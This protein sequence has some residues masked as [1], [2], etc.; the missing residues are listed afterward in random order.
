MRLVSFEAGAA[1]RF[2]AMIGDQIAD[3]SREFGVPTLREALRAGFDKAAW[4]AASSTA[5]KYDAKD[6]TF[7]PPITDMEKILCVGFNYARHT[8]E[9]GNE[10]PEYPSIFVRF[11]DSFVGHGQPVVA[12]RNSDQF[13][14]E[15]ELGVVIS[16]RARHVSTSDAL[17]YVAGY[18]CVAENSV[19]DYQKHSRQATAGK[20][21]L[22]SGSIGPWLVTAD[23]IPDPA[24]LQLT[25]RVNGSVMQQETTGGMVF[26]VQALIAYI[27]T[28]TELNTGDVIATG[29]PAGV[30]SARKPPAFLKPGDLVEVEIE[31]I[32]SLSNTV[33][34]ER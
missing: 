19:R 12:P 14:F 30:G 24:A 18:T 15:G 31:R 28:F 21:F 7:L 13:D 34:A 16:R 11:P 3:L 10:L 8:V 23:E 22:A 2:G 26:G 20:N 27:T 33:E 29:T 9:T 6:V 1:R 5:P 32:G 25:T 17:D 4:E